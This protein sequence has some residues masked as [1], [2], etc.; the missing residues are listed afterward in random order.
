M[1]PH[2]LRQQ[3]RKSTEPRRLR[4]P[5]VGQQWPLAGLRKTRVR[6]RQHRVR[7]P[8]VGQRQPRVERRQQPGGQREDQ[9][10]RNKIYCFP[11]NLEK[12][13]K[14]DEIKFQGRL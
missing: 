5:R 1:E 14:N 11:S 4:Q 8:R 6:Q 9:Q 12:K 10:L 3:P 13:I 2:R 7:Q